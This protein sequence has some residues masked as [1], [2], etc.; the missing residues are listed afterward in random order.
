MRYIVGTQAHGVPLKRKL[1]VRCVMTYQHYVRPV[2]GCKSLLLLGME[3]SHPMTLACPTKCGE[4][5]GVMTVE[6]IL[7]A[8]GVLNCIVRI[9]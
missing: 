1:T 4:D 9:C 2:G 5:G 6:W 8:R 3:C 7:V